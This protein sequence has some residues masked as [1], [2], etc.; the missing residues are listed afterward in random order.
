M[1]AIDFHIHVNFSDDDLRKIAKKVGVKFSA[2]GLEEE[3]KKNGVEVAV[4]ISYPNEEDWKNVINLARKLPLYPVL[5]INVNKIQ[6]NKLKKYLK[7]AIGVKIYLGY[8]YIFPND[9]KLVKIYKLIEKMKKLVIFHTGDTLYS[10]AKLKYAHPLNVDEV[11]VDFPDMKIVIAHAGIPW[12]RDTAEVVNKNE[13]VYTDI[14]GW[15]ETEDEFKSFY[16]KI[17]QKDLKFLIEYCGEEK[18][19]YG[20]DWPLIRMGSYLKFLK[21]T[22]L[23]QSTLRKIL[24]ENGKELLSNVSFNFKD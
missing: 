14:S 12:I 22:K 17:I 24:W 23:K 1:K 19:L 6:M 16:A 15:F 2:K 18:I 8:D 10:W 11:A 9:K 3:M 4:A 5:G 7:H 13:N 21:S 20:T